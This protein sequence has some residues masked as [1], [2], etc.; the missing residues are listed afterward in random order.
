MQTA[1]RSFSSGSARRQFAT[2]QRG[3]KTTAAASKPKSLV[4]WKPNA[5]YVEVVNDAL[6]ELGKTTRKGISRYA[7][8]QHIAV[9]NSLSE[10]DLKR[11]SDRSLPSILSLCD[12]HAAL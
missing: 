12:D 3:S 11:V 8:M 10:A 4:P 5:P 2:D 7:V 6:K 1:R 9:K